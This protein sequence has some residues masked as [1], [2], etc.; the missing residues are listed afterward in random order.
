MQAPTGPKRVSR[1]R[2]RSGRSASAFSEW[3][4]IRPKQLE[5][6]ETALRFWREGD[7]ARGIGPAPL[8]RAP[9][10]RLLPFPEIIPL[11]ILRGRDDTF[12]RMPNDQ[13]EAGIGLLQGTLDLL[14][15]RVLVAG[16]MHG[17][18]ISRRLAELSEDWLSVDEGS[19]YPCLYRMEK[20]GWIRSELGRSENNRRARFYSLTKGGSEQLEAEREDW[21]QFQLAVGR[22]LR[23]A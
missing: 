21:R 2:A 14:V 7:F 6:L 8:G 17:Y 22:V 12:P 5:P 10:K 19:L 9:I 18:A 20:K 16:S 4:V 3:R 13:N 11:D 15:L 1:S 23:R